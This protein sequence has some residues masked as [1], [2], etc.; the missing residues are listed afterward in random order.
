MKAIKRIKCLRINLIKEMKN[1]M[2]EIQR[3]MDRYPVLMDW[4]N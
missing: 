1:L 3:Q 2:K 4:K